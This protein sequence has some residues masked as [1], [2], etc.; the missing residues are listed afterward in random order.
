[1]SLPYY[2]NHN[3]A[4]TEVYK[5]SYYRTSEV[6]EVERGVG[7]F[8]ENANF[9]NHFRTANQ[10]THPFHTANEAINPFHAADQ[11]T[12][13]F[14]TTDQATDQFPRITGSHVWLGEPH[15]PPGRRYSPL[16]PDRP[17]D[18]VDKA[19]SPPHSTDR[20]TGRVHIAAEAIDPFHAADQTTGHFYTA[21]QATDQF[22]RV[23]GSHVLRGELHVP[24][25]H[26]YSPLSRDG[27]LDIV[28]KGINPSHT[29]DQATGQFYTADQ[30]TDQFPRITKNHIRRSELRVSPGRR[31]S[32]LLRGGPLDA[33]DKA[34]DPS[35]TADQATDQFN[36][37]DQATDEAIFRPHTGDEATSTP[38]AAAVFS[39]FDNKNYKN[40]ESAISTFTE[41]VKAVTRGLDVVGEIHPFIK[42]AVLAFK[43]VVSLDLVRRENNDK[44]LAIRLRMKDMMCVLLQLQRMKDPEDRGPDGVTIKDRMQTLIERIARSIRE[45]GSACD[46]YMKKSFLSRVLK[47]KIYEH[48]LAGWAKV[49]VNYTLEL[50]RAV[51]VHIALGVDGANQKLDKQQVTLKGIENSML[52]I[53]RKLETPRE[54][55]VAKFLEDNGG[56]KACIEK[57]SLLLKLVAKTGDSIS[58]IAQRPNPKGS[59]EVGAARKNL[60]K[61]LTEDVDEIFRKNLAVYEAKMA[62]QSQQVVDV[63]ERQGYQIM[64]VLLSGTHDKIKD[65]DLQNLWKEMGWK[66]SVKAR[67]FVLALRDYFIDQFN[68]MTYPTTPSIPV[69]VPT[70]TSEHSLDVVSSPAAED[71]SSHIT[72]NDQWILDHINITHLQPIIEVIDDDGTGFIS[73][74]EANTFAVQ[75]PKGWTLLHW[76]AFWAKGWHHSVS[77]YK[78]QI[79]L[80]IQ[81]MHEGLHYVKPDNKMTVVQY[82]ASDCF[83]TIEQLLRSTKTVDEN[84]RLDSELTKLTNSYV[85][86]EERQLEQNL[87]SVEYNIDSPAT[88]FLSLVPDELRG[89]SQHIYPLLYLILKHHVRIVRTACHHVLNINELNHWEES[90]SSIVTIIKQR[91]EGL[92]VI[93][94]QVYV[95]AQR[96][97]ENFAFGMYCLIHESPDSWKPIDNSFAAWQDTSTNKDESQVDTFQ[98]EDIELLHYPI[99]DTFSYASID[100]DLPPFRLDADTPGYASG[101]DGIWTGH[102]HH[103]DMD[104]ECTSAKGLFVIRITDVEGESLAG[105]VES[106]SGQAMVSGTVQG[107]QGALFQVEM[108]LHDETGGDT[109]YK[110]SGTFDPATQTITGTYETEGEEE[111]EEEEGSDEDEE[112]NGGN[113]D[114]NSDEGCVP[115]PEEEDMGEVYLAYLDEGGSECGWGD[116]KQPEDETDLADGQDISGG[117]E[118]DERQEYFTF[119]LTRTPPELY[120][121][122]YTPEE[123]EKNAARARW[124]FARKAALYHVQRNRWTWTFLKERMA[125]RRRVVQLWTRWWK[126]IL[127]L[128]PNKSLTSEEVDDL[129]HLYDTLSPTFSGL[130]LALVQ[131]ISE[132]ELYFCY[133]CDGCGRG[134]LYPGYFCLQCITADHSNQI[135]L[136]PDCMDKPIT[137]DNFI[138]DKTHSMLKTDSVLPDYWIPFLIKEA[139]ALVG[140]IKGALRDA[141]ASHKSLQPGVKTGSQ[142]TCAC[143]NEP[144]SL[145]CYVCASCTQ[146]TFICNECDSK[147]AEVLSNRPSSLHERFH[148]LIRL[149][150]TSEEKFERDAKDVTFKRLEGLEKVLED[151]VGALEERLGK[152][153]SKLEGKLEERFNSFE[154]LLRQLIDAKQAPIE[155]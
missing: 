144:V 8:A 123:F 117:A 38:T 51:T 105:R 152:L 28:D 5:A 31:Y 129:H 101:I 135:N 134:I 82:L 116:D 112:Y 2:Q 53:F 73:I 72:P 83:K 143:C 19:V 120:H 87:K 56:A 46:V 114:R 20:A 12:G 124:T 43:V 140:R 15:V 35:P 150:D 59:D 42:A 22:P 58:S 1:M 25:G 71:S 130:C 61:E 50:D 104:G 141:E 96:Q 88:V 14:Y 52:E 95:D 118:E 92:K 39:S 132:R 154:L 24:P 142:F 137:N 60:L 7:H 115:D 41:S 4:M 64:S 148:T 86:E 18:T 136:C 78:N 149:F 33:I 111:E 109:L 138:H 77:S 93:Y 17:L 106:Y 107:A 91:V 34:I 37:T 65:T 80:L 9:L 74:K 97:L 49:F 122:R 67:H 153:E 147:D 99:Q 139:R 90:L 26:R 11:T 100:V 62:I 69:A 81:Q 47:S 48:R 126:E 68:V 131:Y 79:Y 57:D 102:C 103:T 108:T 55:E 21:D 119:I 29:T 155:C 127:E 110:L 3:T 76:L 125:E 66:G 44:V 146:D 70:S 151:R 98:P 63:V 36:T 89:P 16:L 6:G 10:A 13:H 75:R 23:T 54:R 45:C 133:G 32:S 121:C 85:M 27:P 84:E 113:G 128:A 145:P 40:I 94:K 30:A